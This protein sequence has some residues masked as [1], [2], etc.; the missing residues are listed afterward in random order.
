M[1]EFI[2]DI[3]DVF[4]PDPKNKPCPHCGGGQ[5]LNLC[6]ILGDQAKQEAPAAAGPEE[7]E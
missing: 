5:C 4:F 3:L 6:G 1:K 2:K 7:K